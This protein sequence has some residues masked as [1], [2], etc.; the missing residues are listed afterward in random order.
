LKEQAVI[1]KKISRLCKQ[2]KL[3]D[4]RTIIVDEDLM[5]ITLFVKKMY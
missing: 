4:N 3:F 2:H 5:N 1:M